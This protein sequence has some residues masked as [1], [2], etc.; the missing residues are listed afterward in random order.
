MQTYP[1]H[2][3]NKNLLKG[4][5]SYTIDKM[6]RIA[7]FQ[8]LSNVK[9]NDLGITLNQPLATLNAIAFLS[10]PEIIGKHHG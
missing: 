2:M 8:P 4:F 3:Y 1:M 10:G 6:T 9:K 5:E 7:N